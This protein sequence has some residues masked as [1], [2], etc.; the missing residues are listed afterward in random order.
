MTTRAVILCGSV[1]SSVAV[2]CSYLG[3]TTRSAVE[4]T[5]T[6]AVPFASAAAVDSRHDPA[7]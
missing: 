1:R 7:F 2:R 5:G 3:A 4:A 6:V